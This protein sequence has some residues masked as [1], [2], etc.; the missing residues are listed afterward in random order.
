MN[1]KVRPLD[2]EGKIFLL[3]VLKKGYFDEADM[4]ILSKMIVFNVPIHEWINERFNSK[5]IEVEIIDRREQ[6]DKDEL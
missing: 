6:V 1:E 4:E 3:S 2:K 5:K